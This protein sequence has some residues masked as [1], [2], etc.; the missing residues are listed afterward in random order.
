MRRF[1]VL[2]IGILLSFGALAADGRRDTSKVMM[3]GDTLQMMKGIARK[4]HSPHKATI[5]AMVLPAPGRFITGSGGRSYYFVWGR[6]C[7]YIWDYLESEAVQGVSGCLYRM[8]TVFGC[9]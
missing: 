2:F 6:G 8:G 9:P 5:M 3:G 4:P 1:V 7:R